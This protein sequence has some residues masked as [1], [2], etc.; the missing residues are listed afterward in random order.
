MIPAWDLP[1]NIRFQAL[2]RLI[3]PLKKPILRPYKEPWASVPNLKPFPLIWLNDIKCL[4]QVYNCDFEFKNHTWTNGGCFC[5]ESSTGRPMIQL[6]IGGRDSKPTP[7]TSY[8]ICTILTHE[9]AHAIQ[10]ILYG[11]A[12]ESIKNFKTK[13]SVHLAY[14]QEACHLAYYIYKEYFTDLTPNIHYNS[15]KTYHNK[16]A[17]CLLLMAWKALQGMEDDIGITNA[18]CG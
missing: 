2:R 1:P 11:N 5:H 15:F 18:F 10:H 16:K 7:P 3:R 6:Y 12:L 9:L 17:I 4:C 14:E 13:L 8:D